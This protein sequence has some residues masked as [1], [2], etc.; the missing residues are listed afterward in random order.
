[1]GGCQT[2][3]HTTGRWYEDGAASAFTASCQAN[4]TCVSRTRQGLPKLELRQLGKNPA[5]ELG[6]LGENP[7]REFWQLGGPPG[8]SAVKRKISWPSKQSKGSRPF[9][10]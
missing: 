3:P 4:A 8:P 1:M 10:T 9:N 5:R 6:Q 7:A 2:D